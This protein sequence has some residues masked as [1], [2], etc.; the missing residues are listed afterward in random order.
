MMLFLTV[1]VVLLPMGY[2]KSET[3]QALD[4]KAGNGSLLAKETREQ[5]WNASVIYVFE[6][7]PVAFYR[8]FPEGT[9]EQFYAVCVLY[10]ELRYEPLHCG[11]AMWNGKSYSAENITQDEFRSFYEKCSGTNLPTVDYKKRT[12]K[13]D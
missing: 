3:C 13:R 4:F 5:L 8:G 6:D 11:K 1:F 12:V 9:E 7:D 2:P 10:W